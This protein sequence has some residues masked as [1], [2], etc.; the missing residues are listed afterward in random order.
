[1]QAQL[2]KRTV[3]LA[4]WLERDGY[5]VRV[6]DCHLRGVDIEIEEYE[7]R[8]RKSSRRNRLIDE[9]PDAGIN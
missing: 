9:L 8:T 1:M 7:R 5:R 3:P 6:T 4:E 2:I